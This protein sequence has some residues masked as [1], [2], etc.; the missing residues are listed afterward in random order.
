M[1]S[2]IKFF[3]KNTIL[4]INF[5]YEEYFVSKK[6]KEKFKRDFNILLRKL[7]KKEN[8]SYSRF[9]D[10][11]LFVLQNKKL[12][13]SKNYWSLEDKKYYANFSNDDKKEFLPTK[14]QFYRKKLIQSLKF[15]KKNY[16]KGISCSCCNGK[17]AVNYM[18]SIAKDDKNL[19]HSNLLQNGNYKLFITKMLSLFKKKKI[20]L[21]S[22]KN[23][24][25]KKL[26]F[27]VIKRFDIGINC[28][29]N[30][31]SVLYKIINYIKKYKIKNH[32]FLFSASSL[33][34]VLIMELY[35]EFDENTYIDIGSTLNPYFNFKTLS[36]SR[37]YL[38][39]YWNSSKHSKHL[40]K[41]CYW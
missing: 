32:V 41:N 19:T 26:P 9:S 16:F 13:I 2:K 7:E 25:F 34:N 1:I 14:H 11:E 37:S 21:I 35:R 27:S 10:G 40:K 22:N 33:S 6:R 18:K 36:K 29:V 8:F 38:S 12:I 5:L 23:N 3:L 31:Y 39:E 24:D 30:D 20:V 4:I 17:T 28:F 15:K